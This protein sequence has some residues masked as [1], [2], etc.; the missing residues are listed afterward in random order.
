L[1]NVKTPL[2]EWSF[3]FVHWHRKS[4]PSKSCGLADEN[5]KSLTEWKWFETSILHCIWIV[6]GVN[7]DLT[8]SNVRF[9]GSVSRRQVKLH[10]RPSNPNWH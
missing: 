8:V 4:I 3:R 6:S 9:T 1:S 2:I 7:W 10:F 5:K